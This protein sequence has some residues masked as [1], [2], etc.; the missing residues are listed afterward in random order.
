MSVVNPTVSAGVDQSVTDSTVLVLTGVVQQG[1]YPLG[2]V[3]W[4]RDSG[5]DCAIIQ[6]ATWIAQVYQL[7]AGTYVFR[8]T[9]YDILG[10]S[11][12]DTMSVTVTHTTG[13]IYL[14][15]AGDTENFDP[16]SE[17]FPH[18]FPIDLP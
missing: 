3:L 15:S 14:S 12:S 11:A 10:N 9:G 18:N 5:P 8:F 1:T 17:S 2:R 4:T 6:S 16:S 13:P 7:Y